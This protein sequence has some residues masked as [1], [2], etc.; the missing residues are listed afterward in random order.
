MKK[1]IVFE[2][3]AGILILVSALYTYAPKSQCMWRLCACCQRN[4]D[5]MRVKWHFLKMCD[6]VFMNYLCNIRKYKSRGDS[7]YSRTFDLNEI[8]RRARIV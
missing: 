3:A 6:C 7:N 5:F 4:L 1:R 8:L 2:L